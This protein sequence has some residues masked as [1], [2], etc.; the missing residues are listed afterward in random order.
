VQASAL[1]EMKQNIYDMQEFFEGYMNLRKGEQGLNG[2]LEQPTLR[3]LLPNLQ[4]CGF[5]I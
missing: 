1:G 2:V 4:A 5:S 3:S